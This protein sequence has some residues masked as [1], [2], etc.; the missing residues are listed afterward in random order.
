MDQREKRFQ[1]KGRTDDEK[2]W[3]KQREEK[4]Y[5]IKDTADLLAVSTRTVRRSI[6]QKKLATHRFGR[7]V[8]IAD[9][10]LDDF[11]ARHRH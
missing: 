4:F 1:S 9:S 5:T 6:D 11:I 10:D 3:S 7:S 2:R 8:R